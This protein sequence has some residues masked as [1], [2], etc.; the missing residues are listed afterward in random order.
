VNQ[1]EI[2]EV[3]SGRGFLTIACPSLITGLAYDP[4]GQWVAGTTQLGN[5]VRIRDARN[6][7]ELGSFEYPEGHLRGVTF[8]H[9]GTRLAA[10]NGNKI[11]IWTR[12]KLPKVNGKQ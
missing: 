12:S 4:E 8:S 5:E 11:R 7:R 3:D 6:G 2:T 9:D 1:V 10:W